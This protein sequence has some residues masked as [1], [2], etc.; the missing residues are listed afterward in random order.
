MCIDSLCLLL[1]IID[2]VGPFP[3]DGRANDAKILR[4]M[5]HPD[6]TYNLNGAYP[7]DPLLSLVESGDHFILD[8]GFRDVQKDLTELGIIVSMPLFLKKRQKAFTC[9]EANMTRKVTMVRWPVEAVNGKVKNKFDFLDNIIPNSYLP[10]IKDIVR[11]SCAILNKFGKP[12]VVESEKHQHFLQQ[13]EARVDMPNLLQDKVEEFQLKRRVFW[14]KA[15]ATTVVGFPR[16]MESDVLEITLGPYQKNQGERYIERDLKVDPLYTVF[17]HKEEAGILR[18]KLQSRFRRAVTHNLW[19]EYNDDPS[20]KPS[21]RILGW[22]CCCETGARNL[23]C[24]SHVAAVLIHLGKD[25][26]EPRKEK[27]RRVGCFLLLDSAEAAVRREARL[28]P[29]E[30]VERED[31]EPEDDRDHWEDF[32]QEAESESSERL[33]RIDESEGMQMESGEE[34][35]DP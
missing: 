26:Y 30:D 24:C 1:Q 25:M 22:Y 21:S 35:L 6:E 2:C 34:L 16:L 18:V 23:G 33:V 12:F 31:V 28:E 19:I 8:R 3:A 7:D 13:V 17:V 29:E 9:E 27:K 5:L 32:E 20:R 14:T 4:E 11:I 15:S 10:A